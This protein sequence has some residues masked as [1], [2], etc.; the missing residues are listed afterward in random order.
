MIT[1]GSRYEKSVLAQVELP[2]G[3]LTWAVFAGRSVVYSEIT[4]RYRTALAGDRF[5]NMAAREYSNPLLWWVIARANPEI[6]YPDEIPAGAV[7]R[8][9]DAA[10]VR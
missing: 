9:P 3:A 4:F 6:F 10:S 2:N 7:I 1:D 5:D 8:I